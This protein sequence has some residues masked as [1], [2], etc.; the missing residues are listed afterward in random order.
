MDARYALRKVQWLAECA[1]APE[2][3]EQVMPRLHPFMAPFVDPFGGHALHQYATTS[4]PGLLSDVER[5]NVASIA[6]HCGQDRLGLQRFIGWAAWDDA[7]V[8]QALRDHVGP[9]WGPEDGVLVCDPSAFPTSGRESVGVARQWCG[10]LGT[11]E[12]CQVARDLG[13]VSRKGHTL[14]DRRLSLPHS[15]DPRESPPGPSWGAQSPPRLPHPSPV[16]LGDAG[17]QWGSAPAWVD[18]G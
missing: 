15:M 4:I 7:P 18:G 12:N 8:R 11:G 9:Q 13:Y 16:R 14:V 1:G 2:V 6:A 17:D 5:K 3:F 10:R